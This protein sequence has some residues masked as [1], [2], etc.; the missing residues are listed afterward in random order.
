MQRRAFT[1]I[2]LLVVI[3]IIAILAAILFPVFAQAKLAAKKTAGLSQMKQIGMASQLYQ[4]DYDDGL[5]TWDSYYAVYP[6]SNRDAV[7]AAG[8]SPPSYRRMWDALLE[9]YV[10]GGGTFANATAA[11]NTEWSGLWRSPGAEYDAK[12]G[13]SIGISLLLTY[14][15][16]KDTVGASD[17]NISNG[18]YRWPTAS[19]IEM[20]SDTVF[21]GDSG[22]NGRVDPPHWYNAFVEAWTT[23]PAT[24]AWGRPWRYGKDSANYVFAD[25]H[26]K[27]EKGD[28]MYPNPGH[29]RTFQSFTT[30]ERVPILCTSAKYY[31]A[32]AEEKTLIRS[33]VADN[34]A[35][36]Q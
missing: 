25:G 6:A 22:T 12:K 29:N 26:A 18:T 10:K 31:A 35:N 32:S 20:P 28:K 8:G 13:R 16:S 21:A 9:P 15:I 27:S 14:D 7:F 23:P 2:E 17:T 24:P 4:G 34:C 19:I 36:L 11:A 3:A 1:L 30:A 33:K 5:P